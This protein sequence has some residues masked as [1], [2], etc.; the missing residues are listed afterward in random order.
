MSVR[1]DLPR[2]H[3]GNGNGNRNGNRNG[4]LVSQPEV[5]VRLICSF[6]K[7]RGGSA[8]SVSIIDYFERRVRYEDKV[9]FKSLLKEIASLEKRP[10]GSRW[11]LKP[12][13]RQQ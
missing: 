4:N 5:L 1:K 9:L 2:R 7:E 11:V 8:D 12:E 10:N 13:Y 3:W 6:L